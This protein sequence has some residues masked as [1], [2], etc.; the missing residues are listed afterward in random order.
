MIAENIIAHIG[1]ELNGQAKN[2]GELNSTY[3]LPIKESK[4]LCSKT[5]PVA[6]LI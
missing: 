4:K 5:C 1:L 3:L 6:L 2:A